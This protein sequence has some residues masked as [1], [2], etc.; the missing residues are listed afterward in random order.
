VRGLEA[1]RAV[2][3]IEDVVVSVKTGQTLR[4]LPEGSTYLGFT[5]ARGESPEQVERALRESFAELRFEVTPLLPIAC[6]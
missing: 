4:A 1:A 2:A 5:F 6:S 3:C